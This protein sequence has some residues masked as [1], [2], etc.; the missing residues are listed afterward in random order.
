MNK[1]GIYATLSLICLLA[2]W[3]IVMYFNDAPF[4]RGFTGDV[5]IIF[6]VYF[7]IRIFRDDP[8]LNL[9]I[10]TLM[11]AFVTE[12]LQYFKLAA[13]LG[14]EHNTAFKLILG[15]VFDPYDLI[16]YCIGAIGVYYF[17]TWLIQ[18]VF[19]LPHVASVKNSS[20]NRAR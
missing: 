8:A 19:G 5:I 16:A 10:F 7:L 13:A 9:A 6:M 11:V 15:S 14:L 2:C 17:D 12:G 18:V 4:I 3:L 1:R 20:A